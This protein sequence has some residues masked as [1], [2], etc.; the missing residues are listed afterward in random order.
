[1]TLH[2]TIALL[3]DTTPRLDVIPCLLTVAVPLHRQAVTGTPPAPYGLFSPALTLSP[4]LPQS[5]ALQ[6]GCVFQD[7]SINIS[8][9]HIN[10]C[11]PCAVASFLGH[12]CKKTFFLFFLTPMEKQ[13][14]SFLQPLS[15]GQ[16]EQLLPTKGRHLWPWKYW[17][18]VPGLWEISL[19]W[20]QT[21]GVSAAPQ[22]GAPCKDGELIK[23]CHA[24][25]KQIFPCHC[26]TLAGGRGYLFL[27]HLPVCPHCECAPGPVRV[28]QELK[29]LFFF[30]APL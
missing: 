27:Y 10:D 3:N 9:R 22:P 13:I 18:Q 8:L 2:L 21:Q 26:P 12:G 15:A 5:I 7:R 28:K 29:P 11:L 30:R 23:I 6:R 20:D 25:P 24:L 1:M 17:Q 14:N 4:I 19:C 16:Q